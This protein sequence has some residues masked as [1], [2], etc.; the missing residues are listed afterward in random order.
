[1]TWGSRIFTY[2]DLFKAVQSERVVRPSRLTTILPLHTA[3]MSLPRLGCG[4]EKAEIHDTTERQSGRCHMPVIPATGML[5]HK[6][7]KFKANLR[8]IL[9]TCLNKNK[10][11]WACSSVLPGF[12]SQ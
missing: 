11:G 6:D 4:A 9:R 10:K 2:A 8:C 12:N 5:R 3:R 1:M 7:L